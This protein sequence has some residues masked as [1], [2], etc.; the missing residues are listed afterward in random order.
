MFYESSLCIQAVNK[1]KFTF[2]TDFSY[3]STY[4]LKIIPIKNYYKS[5]I[6]V[7][8]DIVKDSFQTRIIER[9]LYSGPGQKPRCS[10]WHICLKGST[11]V[12][13]G[14][15]YEKV[16]RTNKKRRKCVI[17]FTYQVGRGKLHKL[18]DIKYTLVF[19]FRFSTLTLLM[20]CDPLEVTYTFNLSHEDYHND[21]DEV[22][23]KNTIWNWP[24]IITVS[25]LSTHLVF[26][27]Y[28]EKRPTHK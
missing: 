6:S 13:L 17:L 11:L 1:I 8:N 7:I 26:Y 25:V 10:L 20:I 19:Y 16:M 27:N 28:K 2:Y 14:F 3:I 24:Y 18:E 12:I 4:L 23:V 5:N 9:I 15:Q 21:Y 22:T